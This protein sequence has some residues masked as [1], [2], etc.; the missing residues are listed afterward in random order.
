MEGEGIS[1]LFSGSCRAKRKA[2]RRFPLACI[3]F[4]WIPWGAAAQSVE[5]TVSDPLGV[6]LGGV[7]V[8]VEPGG[9]KTWTDPSG[10]FRF[11]NLAAGSL[12]LRALSDDFEPVEAQI[13]LDPDSA[14]KQNLQFVSVRRSETSIEVVGES[15]KLCW[16]FQARFS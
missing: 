10:L 3:L 7:K 2:L 9:V 6:P 14:V 15:R 16:K 1:S 4:L 12:I 8:V 13:H 5:G 11:E